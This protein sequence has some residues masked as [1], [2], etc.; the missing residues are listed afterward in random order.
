MQILQHFFYILKKK[1]KKKTEK[2]KTLHKFF[3]LPISGWHIKMATFAVMLPACV[4]VPHNTRLI[5]TDL[6]K[7]SVA[8]VFREIHEEIPKEFFVTCLSQFG[9]D[10]DKIDFSFPIRVWFKSI[11]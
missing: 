11:F 8:D 4:H 3:L 5:D 10:S 1:R 6:E 2:N 7:Y 9:A